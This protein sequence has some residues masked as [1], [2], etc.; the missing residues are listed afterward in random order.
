MTLMDMIEGDRSPVAEFIEASDKQNIKLV[1][2]VLCLRQ[3]QAPK[4]Y[5]SCAQINTRWLSLSRSPVAEL[6]E[7]NR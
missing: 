4:K 7:A 2:L 5:S 6:V 3:A 1:Q